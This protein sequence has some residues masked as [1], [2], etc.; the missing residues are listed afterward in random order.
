MA[1]IERRDDNIKNLKYEN[2]DEWS[3]GDPRFLRTFLQN[4]WTYIP[5]T[6]NGDEKDSHEEGTRLPLVRQDRPLRKGGFGEVTKEMILPGH[7]VL[8]HSSD[9]LGLSNQINSVSVL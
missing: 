8:R 2:L 7:I 4:R 5:I 9:H 1:T 6:L 3:L